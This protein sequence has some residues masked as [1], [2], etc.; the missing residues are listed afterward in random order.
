MTQ[1]Y[2]EYETN[3]KF[4]NVIRRLRISVRML[5]AVLMPVDCEFVKITLFKAIKVKFCV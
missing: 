4:R 1:S 2:K 3:A 5:E